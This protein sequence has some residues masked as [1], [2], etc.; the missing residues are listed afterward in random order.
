M[1]AAGTDLGRTPTRRAEPGAGR[2]VASAASWLSSLPAGLWR[3]RAEWNAAGLSLALHIV[4]LLMLAALLIP[5]QKPGS[6]TSIDGGL[7]TE[8]GSGEPFESITI[9]SPDPG[10]KEDLEQSIAK[11]DAVPAVEDALAGSSGKSGAGGSGSFNAVA[12]LGSGAGGG[13]SGKGVGFFGTQAR[14]ESV[15]FVVDMSGSMSGR[16][17]SRAVDELVRSLGAL[18]PSQRFWVFF[19]NGQTHPL[20]DQK[21]AKLISA[22]ES[23]RSKA[24]KW[25]KAQR[26]EGDTYPEDALTQALK[27]NPQVIFFL[28][29][30]EIPDTTLE[31]VHAYNRDRKTVIHTIAFEYEG[32]AEILKSIARENRGKYRFVP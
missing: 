29:D 12:A 4:V 7:G 22:T 2:F 3:S 8:E 20:F 28:T 10:T 17:F 26:P 25:I 13:G 5:G 30:G 6:G 18:I 27:L 1:A 11:V 9:G 32:G 24:V 31:T 19:Y 23:S 15:V 21:R 16:R 14:A